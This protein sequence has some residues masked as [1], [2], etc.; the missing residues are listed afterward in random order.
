MKILLVFFLLLWINSYQQQKPLTLAKNT[1]LLIY[2]FHLTHRCNTCVTIEKYT[3][4]VLEENFKDELKSKV[5]IFQSFNCETPENKELVKEYN[6]YGST[7]ALTIVKNKLK[8]NVDDIT[9]WAF[10]KV[11]N[12]DVFKKELK[13]KIKEYLELN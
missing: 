11:G 4:E 7:L 6:A 10:S 12:E 3:K 5:I 8:T 9:G 13:E 2:Y 1:K